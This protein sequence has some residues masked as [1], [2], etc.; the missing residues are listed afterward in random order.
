VKYKRIRIHFNET[1]FLI[2][3]VGGAFLE[4]QA[5]IIERGIGVYLRWGNSE[6][7]Q[8]GR[9]WDRDRQNVLARDKIANLLTTQDSRKE[10][11]EAFRTLGQVYENLFPGISQIISREKFLELYYNYPGEW[12]RFMASPLDLLE[13]DADKKWDRVSFDNRAGWV[14]LSFLDRENHPI[15]EF[16]ISVDQ[17]DEL[18][19]NRSVIKGTLEELDFP[20]DRLFPFGLLLPILRALDPD[21]RKVLLPDPR[22]FLLR[23]YH[24]TRIGFAEA[25]FSSNFIPQ[26]T[27]GI[28]YQTDFYP[29]VLSIMVPMETA[30]NILSQIEKGQDVLGGNPGDSIG[31]M[32][33]PIE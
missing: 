14:N 2:F 15:R 6:R 22:W 1:I 18:Q 20:E 12:S 23:N 4:F 26:I 32:D 5:H 7:S 3:L 13:I 31:V 9:V 27:I 10:T 21:S 11:S 19:S 25:P 29:H 24:V 33:D 17:L 28:E 30:Y 16:N 8:L